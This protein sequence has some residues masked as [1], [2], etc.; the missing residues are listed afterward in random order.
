M[1]SLQCRNGSWRVLF[2]YKGK[3][4]T[5][6]IGETDAIEAAGAKAQAEEI[7]RLLKRN[8]IELPPGCSIEDFL[9]HRGKP[10]EHTNGE[11]P[12]PKEVTLSE[13]R[14]SYVRT[15]SNGTIEQ[16]TLDTSRLHL[17]HFAATLGKAFPVSVLSLSDLQRHVNRRAKTKSRTGKL[18]SPTTIKK[19]IATFSS[20]WNW[21]A[22]MGMVSGP[23]PAEGLRYP[24][25]QEPPPFMT[26]Q[27]IERAVECGGKADE[28][29]DCLYLTTPE[30]EELLSFVKE[31]AAHPFIHP[32]FSFA[33]HT[34]ARRSEIMR[35]QL[36]DLDFPGQ[37]VLIREKKRAKGKRTTRRVPL[38]PFLAKVL[39]EWVK[40][41]PGGPHL[42]CLGGVVGRSKKRSRTTGHKG[43]KTRASGLKARLSTVT[44][45]GEVPLTSLS[46]KETHDHVKRTLTGS[47]WEVLKGWHVLRHS[48][49]S[50]CASKAV[51]QRMLDDWVGHQT[52]EQRKRYRH[53]Y[54]ST[55]QE[56][57]KLVFGV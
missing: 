18:V 49:I 56:A 40:V 14:D 22:K 16:N 31:H 42:F 48:F 29:W 24:K 34:G 19:E 30:I 6:T 5:F 43:E 21:G 33:A 3:L 53:L 1:A 38:T 17:S 28:L 55:Q 46:R 23:F 52:D 10:P 32:M 35:A 12:A 37:T 39:K 26:W 27:E 44:Q 47:K 45:R 13:L 41:H 2:R 8:L 15:H 36:L 51:D 50:A 57:I 20:V 4:H 7:L 11:P 9:L 25:T 54:P